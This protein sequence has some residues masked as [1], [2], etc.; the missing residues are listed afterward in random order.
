M[1]SADTLLVI[2]YFGLM[3]S[4]GIYFARYMKTL[5]LYF[6]GGKKLPWWLGG[7]SFLMSYVSALSIVVYSAMGY[8]YGLV[9]ITL[10]AT[11]VPACLVTA[12][13]FARRWHR[14]G[15]STPVE[16]LERRYSAYLRQVFAWSGLPLKIIDEGLKIIAVGLFVSK[17]LGM[18]LNTA[19][20]L[21]G[22]III[23]YTALGGLWAVCIT[24]FIQFVLVT[25]AVL[26]LLPLSLREAGGLRS[27]VA[28]VPQGFFEPLHPPYT[29]FYLLG[30]ILLSTMS[31]AGNWSLVQRFYSARSEQDARRIGW[32]AAALFLLLPPVWIIAG[33]AARVWLPA[34]WAR[35]N[36]PQ[37]VYAEISKRLLPPGL[38]GLIVAALFAAT[39]SVLSAGYN[40]IASVLT[41]DVYRRHIRP[42]ASERSLLAVGKISTA[43]VGLTA[44]SVAW[45]VLHF[46][47]T[48]FDTMVAAFGFFLPPTVLPVLAGLVWPRVTSRGA[49]A[50]FIAGL[51]SGGAFLAA[52]AFLPAAYNYPMQ[53]VSLWVSSA[54]VL[55]AMYLASAS[56]SDA[57]ERAQIAEFYQAL[58]RPAAPAQQAS[59][60][61]PFFISGVVLALLGV[62]LGAIG[63]LQWSAAKLTFWVGALLAALGA[64][65]LL[66]HRRAVRP[67]LPAQRLGAS[68]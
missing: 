9:S 54:V 51:V 50:G 56:A 15:V 47:W 13:L 14:A 55:A 63:A 12:W 22:V 48:I 23:L 27:F 17:G 52:R 1:R 32:L 35:Q 66:R 58:A 16:F 5:D 49:L 44:M 4:V 41:V 29:A 68:Q 42:E 7:I 59:I 18:S 60:P 40:V 25:T 61:E 57:P 20:L 43:L 2:L 36:D 31:M 46:R 11:T 45:L 39:M 6:V 33:M 24:D 64:T 30:F 10:Y 65:L 8:T 62:A 19:I 21:T 38:L 67:A 34:D 53:T 37:Y 26:L 28:H 3:V